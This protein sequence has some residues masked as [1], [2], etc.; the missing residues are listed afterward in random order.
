MDSEFYRLPKS[1]EVWT[2]GFSVEAAVQHAAQRGYFFAQEAIRPDICIAMEEEVG[3]LILEE[4]DH[5]NKPINVGTS[6]EVRQL[7]ERAYLP[8]DHPDVPVATAVTDSLAQSMRNV[9]YVYPELIEWRATE[10]GYQRYRTTSDWISPHRDRRNDQLL[11]ITITINGS[12][13]VRIHEPIDDPD[14]Y[15]NLRVVDEFRTTPGSVMLLRAYGLGGGEQVIHEVM[16]PEEDSRLILNLRMRPD[17]LK[18]PDW[19][20][21]TP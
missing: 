11:A 7:H 8:I 5:V 12:A 2:K 16:P 13:L 10:A 19:F 4:G 15:K 1:P 17:V 6:R 14:D 3:R 20:N 21:Q 18:N 9:S